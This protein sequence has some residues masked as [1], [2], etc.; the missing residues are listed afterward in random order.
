MSRRRDYYQTLGVSPRAT[1]EEI[2]RAFRRL[3]R[4]HHPDVNPNDPQAE[5]RFKEVA[6]AYE[7]LRDPERRQSYDRFGTAEPGAGLAG[8]F[9]QDLGGFHD[10]FD[11][12]FG[13]R[14]APGRPRGPRRGADLRYHLQ[15]S[16]E[17]VAAGARRTLTVPRADTCEECGGTGSGSGAAPQT[18]ARCRGRGRVEEVASTPFGRLSTITTCSAC[19][20]EGAVIADPCEAC[21]GGGRRTREVEV[22]VSIPAGV[23]EGAGLRIEGEGEAGERGGPRGDLYVVLSVERHEF[24][25]R[26]GRDLQCEVPIP[27]TTAALGG[28]IAVPTLDGEDRLAL[29]AGTQT[30]R[31]FVL[32]GRGLP[33]ARTGVRGSE[34]VVVHV[35]TPPRLTPRQKELLAEFASEGGDQI[36]D[37][38]GW[39]ARVRDAL[40]GEDENP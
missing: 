14:G 18:C 24:F 35:V 32:R 10:L 34:H 11:M 22:P 38:K 1:Q 31:S 37:P 20:G 16:L 26:H 25:T 8:D 15:I 23:E 9:W 2:R 21:G 7:V 17:E 19:R 36:D 29:P 27:F 5:A 12:F 4:R 28:E 30:G 40:R 3:A 6:E 39:F 33:D 13:G